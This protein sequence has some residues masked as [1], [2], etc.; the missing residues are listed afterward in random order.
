[1]SQTTIKVSRATLRRLEK[2][3][4]ALGARTYDEAINALIKEYRRLLL[5][6]NFGVDRGRITSF[7]EEDRLEDRL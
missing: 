5:E 7:T 2:V 1:M 6:R 4:E 3:R